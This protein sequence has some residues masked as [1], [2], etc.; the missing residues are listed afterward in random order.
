[1]RIIRI[2]TLFTNSECVFGL[3]FGEMDFF[4]FSPVF[5]AVISVVVCVVIF[6]SQSDIECLECN[7]DVRK[8]HNSIDDNRLK[9]YY[10]A[11]DRVDK[12]QR[13]THIA[14]EPELSNIIQPPK[15]TSLSTPRTTKL[16]PS[17]PLISHLNIDF[18][19]RSSTV[20]FIAKR[21]QIFRNHKHVEH[22]QLCVF[23]FFFFFGAPFHILNNSLGFN[24]FFFFFLFRF[25]AERL[26]VIV[27]D[28]DLC[29]FALAWAC[30][31]FALKL[32][33]WIWLL[34]L[35]QHE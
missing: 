32:S 17:N 6:G 24:L 26:C 19:K 34:W 2:Y 9:T 23:I 31:R 3:Q 16:K 29:A 18:I 25:G 1:M 22:A 35:F 20:Q 12:D 8:T 15:N 5:F 27:V 21:K 30:F 28:D 14:W 11:P 10:R 4:F 13:H 33:A 7:Y